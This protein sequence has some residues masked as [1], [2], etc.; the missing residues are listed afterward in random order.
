MFTGGYGTET[1]ELHLR[2]VDWREQ[3]IRLRA[4]ITKGHTEAVVYV[5]DPTMALLERW[6]PSGVP[7]APAGRTCSSVSAPRSTE[8]RW[9]AGGCGR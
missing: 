3:E 5:D 6:K 9:T 7:T 1:R 8:S 2:D 4:E